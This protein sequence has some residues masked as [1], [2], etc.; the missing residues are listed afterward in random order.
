MSNGLGEE[1]GCVQMKSLG[2][3]AGLDSGGGKDER[4]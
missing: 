1:S 2:S 3:D 4:V